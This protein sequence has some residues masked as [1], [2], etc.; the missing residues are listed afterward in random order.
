MDIGNGQPIFAKFEFEDWTML[1]TRFELHL[2]LYSFKR[3]L[4]DPDRPG[5]AE[6]HLAF[7]YQ[8]Y[9]SQDSLK[10][11]STQHYNYDS[12]PKFV[13]QLLEGTLTIN[14]KTGF[15]EP[16][17]A[18]DDAPVAE[19]VKQVEDHRRE[20]QDAAHG[21]GRRDRGVEDHPVEEYAAAVQRRQQPVFR[22]TSTGASSG[23]STSA[24]V[25]GQGAV[26]AGRAAAAAVRAAWGAAPGGGAAGLGP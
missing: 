8:K 6:A 21:R 25:W 17:L 10:T 26:P 11:F 14:E 22:T 2:L 16:L 18:E 7:Y 12:F 1:S 4:N 3:D 13:E 23:R 5:F 24:M 20:R 19:F 15:L 9:Y